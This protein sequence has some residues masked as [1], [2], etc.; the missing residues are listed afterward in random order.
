MCDQ[1]ERHPGVWE[2]PI[3]DL[4]ALG[5]PYSMDYGNGE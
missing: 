1:A 2:V 4:T 5:G 3:W